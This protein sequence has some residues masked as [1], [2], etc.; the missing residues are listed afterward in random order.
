[1]SQLTQCNVHSHTEQ[2]KHVA[3]VNTRNLTEKSYLLITPTTRSSVSHYVREIIAF[4]ELLGFLIWRDLLIRYR[5]TVLGIAWVLFQPLAQATVLWWLI[6]RRLFPEQQDSLYPVHVFAGTTLWIYAANSIMGSIHRLSGSGNLITKV[7][8]P[9]AILAI[10]PCLV[11]ILDLALCSFL[12]LIGLTYHHAMNWNLIWLPLCYLG[13]VIFTMGPA[14]LI[15]IV[16]ARYRDVKHL[17]PY[18]VQLWVFATPAIYMPHTRVI[19][20][21]DWLIGAI[22]PLH[23][24][25]LCTASIIRGSIPSLQLWLLAA[26]SSVMYILMGLF[27]LVRMERTL[28]DHL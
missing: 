11:H 1:M 15:G 19:G 9:R 5:Q 21:T 6:G 10:A 24:W 28:S 13:M 16:A 18:F 14:M 12:L 7:Y 4:R 25:V 3:P 17:A 22:N 26:L 27:F 8:F 23:A 2:E 20:N